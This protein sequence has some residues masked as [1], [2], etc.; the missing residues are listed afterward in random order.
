MNAPPLVGCTHRL[1]SLWDMLRNH[2]WNFFML[3]H[4]LESMIRFVEFEKNNPSIGGDPQGIGL[5][6]N[7]SD[8]PSIPISSQLGAETKEQI[9][10]TLSLLKHEFS[11]IGI[12]SVQREIE[13]LTSSLS[14]EYV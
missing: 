7:L 8:Q 11:N 14:A 3:R 12:L 9:S 6:A 2:A 5:L 13:R 4:F 1:W 10:N